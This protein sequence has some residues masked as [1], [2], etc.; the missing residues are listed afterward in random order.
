[1]I[2]AALL[3]RIVT[4]TGSER[5][6]TRWMREDCL[7]WSRLVV[8]ID[9]SY[10][11]PKTT[12][13][14]CSQRVIQSEICHDHRIVYGRDKRWTRYRRIPV[15]VTERTLRSVFHHR[16]RKT[17]FFMN[18]RWVRSVDSIWHWQLITLTARIFFA[19]VWLC[20]TI[21]SAHESSVTPY[22]CYVFTS[23]SAPYLAQIPSRS[24][25]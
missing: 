7:F 10:Q 5:D 23:T 13:I 25:Y 9:W 15:T 8:L 4:G 18:Q 24:Y 20:Q 21:I 2:V 3:D 17:V 1:M 11:I 22:L 14:H 6:S 12:V 16:R 19:V